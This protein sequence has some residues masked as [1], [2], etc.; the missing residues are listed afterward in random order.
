MRRLDG[1]PKNCKFKDLTGMRFGSLVAIRHSVRKHGEHRSWVCQC[2]CGKE[3]TA[4]G[5]NLTTGR[6]LSCG[7]RKPVITE[8]SLQHK[9]KV[10]SR[11]DTAFRSLL[12]NYKHHAKNRNL[13]W[14]LTDAQ[15]RKLTSSPCYYTEHLPSN[16]IKAMSGEVYTYNGVDRLDNNKGYTVENSVPCCGEVNMMK[17]A[18]SKEHFIEL[19]KTIAERF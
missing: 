9:R 6:T 1:K 12:A 8:E 13:T 17:K 18:L 16:T 11:T 7:C 5:Y 19:C 4:F 14:E 15:F 3:H 10:M 2:D